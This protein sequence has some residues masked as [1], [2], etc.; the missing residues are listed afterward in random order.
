MDEDNLRKVWILRKLLHPMDELAAM[1]FLLDRMKET[2]T[3]DDFFDQMKRKAAINF[4][5]ISYQ[6]CLMAAFCFG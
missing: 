1:E 5:V 2:K 4:V 6:G 3:N